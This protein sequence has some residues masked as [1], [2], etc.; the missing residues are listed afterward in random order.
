MRKFQI[1]SRLAVLTISAATPIHAS[2]ATEPAEQTIVVTATP[3]APSELSTP[4]AISVIQG[5]DIRQGAPRVNLSE[6]LGAVPGL[7]IQNRQNYAQDLQLSVRG[8]GSRSTFGVRGLR[9]YVDGIPATMPDGQGQTSNID[10]NSVDSIEVLRGPFSALYGNASGGVINII[11]Q[12][13]QQPPT[14]ESSNW[15]GSYGSWRYGLKASGT[16]GTGQQPG[17]VDYTVS[18]TRF[19]THGFRDDSSARK[20]LANA[21]LGVR[22]NDASKLSL[23]INRVDISAG[24][25]G[26]L[27][28]SEWQANPKSAP[29]AAQF[30]TRKDLQQTQAGLRYERTLSSRDDLIVTAWAGHRNTTQY[31]SIPMGPQ[32]NPSHS[33]GVIDLSRDYQGID[34]RWTHRGALGPILVTLTGGLNYETMREQRKGYENFILSGGQPQYGEQGALRRNETNLMWNV[35]PYLQTTWQLTDKISLD[36]GVRYSSIWF[37][38]DDHYVTRGNGNDSGEASYHQLLP[39]GSLRYALTDGW[40]VY[41]AAGRGYE[42][43]T[44]NELSYRPDGQSGLNFSLKPST[45]GTVEIGSKV[46]I[47]NGLMSSTLFQTTTQNE[48]VV[49]SSSG[50]RTT[51]KNAGQTQRQGAEFSIDEQFAADW[52]LKVAWTWLLATYSNNVCD[53]TNCN[54]NRMPG[55]ARNMG[56]ASFGYLPESGW[57][58]GVDARYLSDIMANDENTAKA[59]SWTVAGLNTGYKWLFGA[60]TLDVFGRVDNLFDRQYAGSVIVNE[61]N[62][63]YF[64]PAPG[65]N[66]ST[67]MT[68]NYRFE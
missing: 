39:V 27:T 37:D 63:R 49:A 62:G 35:D 2:A 66:Y 13:G 29:R 50:G 53:D 4:A 67:G 42:T 30:S 5:D 43:P 65:R 61:S 28:Y 14:L 33:G 31:Q 45:S 55:I 20:N 16:T 44:I 18:S 26:G 56:Y 6:N 10:L 3:G 25:P 40:N 41:L 32:L 48:I 52:R 57:Y 17:D 22:L 38:S 7:Q 47:G 19:T 64:E 68:V 15:Y 34:S 8:F 23:I 1:P 54:G 24:D 36:A 59:P 11:T 12:T 60:W 21:K 58:A 9:I 51:Y 46:R